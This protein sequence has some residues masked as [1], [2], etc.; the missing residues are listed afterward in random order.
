MIEIHRCQL[1]EG[2]WCRIERRHVGHGFDSM[3]H[4]VEYAENLNRQKWPGFDWCDSP[5]E[6]F[7]ALKD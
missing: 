1:V 4:A 7:L 6:A 2:E 5:T 3:A